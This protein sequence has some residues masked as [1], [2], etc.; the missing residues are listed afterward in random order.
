[1]PATLDNSLRAVEMSVC[2]NV[3][4]LTVPFGW[5]DV[6]PLV[7]R[8]LVIEGV[9]YGYTGWNSDRMVAYFKRG[10]IIGRLA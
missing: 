5:D 4:T 7:G 6:K 2:K 8:V 9:P 1:M 3:A 10:G